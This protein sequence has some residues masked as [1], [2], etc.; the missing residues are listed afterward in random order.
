[1]TSANIS[2]GGLAEDVIEPAEESA[3]RSPGGLPGAQQHGGESRTE[4]KR[5]ERGEQDRNRDGDGELFVKLSGNA[6]NERRGNKNRREDEANGNHRAG[7]LLHR[8]N[9]GIVR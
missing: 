1:M 2:V 6:G 5:V 8:L 7:D 9:T 3:Q 4:R